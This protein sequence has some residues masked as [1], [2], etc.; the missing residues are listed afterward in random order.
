MSHHAFADAHHGPFKEGQGGPV[1]VTGPNELRVPP[2]PGIVIG[3]GQQGSGS[4]GESECKKTKE[5]DT[6]EARTQSAH[7]GWVEHFDGLC[8]PLKDQAR[9]DL[10][11]VLGEV[12]SLAG[13]ELKRGIGERWAG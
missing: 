4:H 10:P 7:K 1:I 3:N 5:G 13:K 6:R 12:A 2:G 8:G 9:K 11:R